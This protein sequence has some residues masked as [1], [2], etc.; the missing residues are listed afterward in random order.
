MKRWLQAS[1]ANSAH[2]PPQFPCPS[3]EAANVS[4]W[5]RPEKIIRPQSMDSTEFYDI[6]QI[7]WRAKLGVRRSDARVL[8]DAWYS[9]YSNLHFRNDN[10]CTLPFPWCPF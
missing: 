7:P 9:P 8:R 5:S 6:Q 2:V 3:L 10:V 1:L 4:L